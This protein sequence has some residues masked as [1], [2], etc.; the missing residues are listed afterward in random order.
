MH[1][2]QHFQEVCAPLQ[3]L[4]FFF[5][6]FFFLKPVVPLSL[7][8]LL[9]LVLKELAED[10][11]DPKFPLQS[12]LVRFLDIYNPKKEGSKWI[13]PTPP[14]PLLFFFFLLFADA[15]SRMRESIYF[16]WRAHSKETLLT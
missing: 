9:L 8:L 3:F 13:D 6:F 5:F 4:S 11:E 10:E 14:P 16:I 12:S 15:L 1:V 2:K 7:L